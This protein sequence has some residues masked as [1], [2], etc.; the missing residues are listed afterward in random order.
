M[1]LGPT[2]AGTTFQP[3]QA[4]YTTYSDVTLQSG[5]QSGVLLPTPS[6]DTATVTDAATVTNTFERSII[7]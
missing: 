4:S 6:T 5:A 7:I 2:V 1:S 3:L